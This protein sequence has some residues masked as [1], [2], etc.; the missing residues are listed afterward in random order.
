MSQPSPCSTNDGQIFTIDDLIR[1]RAT[2]LGNATLIGYPKTDVADYEEHSA[3][4]VDG[5]VDAAAHVLQHKGL[6]LVGVRVYVV[7]SAKGADITKNPQ[8]H[9]SVVAILG[10]P[11]LHVIITTLALSRLGYAVLLLSTRLPSP[12]I[13]RLLDLTN[14]HYVL[15]TPNYHSVLEQVRETRQVDVADLLVHQDYCDLHV[16]PI[17]RT[18]D[19]QVERHKTCI[20]IHSSGSTGLPKP[21]F[22]T[23]KSC[24]ASFSTHLN[25]KALITSPF[26]HS[27]CFYET[28]R[29][30][31]SGKPIYYCNYALPLTKASVIAMLNRVKPELFHCVPYVLKLL[32][33]S[34][35]GNNA[36]A[37]VDFVLFAGSACPDDLG[38]DLVKHGVNLNA[39]YGATETGRLM[40]SARPPGDDAWDYLRILPQ[41]QKY[42]LMDEVAPNLYE[43]VALDGLHSKNTINSDTPPQSFRTRDLFTPH[44]TQP[45]L[46]KYA[47]R[48]DDRFT[49]VNGEKVLPLPIEG[50]IRQESAVKEAIVF[51]NG[52]TVPG[53]LIVKSDLAENS[54]NSEFLDYIWP[55]VADANS[56]A[57]GFAQIPKELIVI[58]NANTPYPSTDKGTVIRGLAYTQFESEIEAAY[59]RFEIEIKGGSLTLAGSELEAH[60]LHM[61]K[62]HVG[63][64]LASIDADFFANG[65]DSLQCIKMWN[66]I[67]RSIDLG[68]H[69]VDLGQ[70][71]IYESGCVRSL[72]AHLESLRAGIRETTSDETASMQDLIHRY[73]N[74]PRFTP[75]PGCGHH[76][77]VVVCMLVPLELL[78]P[79]INRSC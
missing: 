47:S 15:T 8:A 76:K 41:V 37:R 24:I 78:L 43:C 26:F 17:E 54:T 12:A 4:A 55:A 68:G 42:V 14:C 53:V 35:D 64:R 39:N 67:K 40:T 65:I 29:S 50:R 11:G 74:F 59:S 7:D 28:F 31:Y 57:E 69:H 63:V 10:Q 1:Q 5:Y 75:T 23:H 9:A 34:E 48:L 61:F 18:Y 51:G 60:L 22:L 58:L 6:E 70:N 71:V 16:P 77:D 13:S 49:L 72:A 21:I 3:R 79:L 19:A 25:R 20:I 45:G 32:A 30:I 56:R 2:Q 73:S 46:W 36:L 66:L 38:N 62:E 27:H 52:R 44:P 33:G